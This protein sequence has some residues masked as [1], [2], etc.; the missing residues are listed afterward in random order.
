MYND[1]RSRLVNQIRFNRC[2]PDHLL[3]HAGTRVH[4]VIFQLG[5]FAAYKQDKHNQEARC[6][7]IAQS[8]RLWRYELHLMLT[9]RRLPG[10]SSTS[11]DSHSL[12]KS[13]NMERMRCRFCH[14][15]HIL[16]STLSLFSA[17]L[18]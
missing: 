16:E 18:D 12:I 17:G 14:E 15:L 13:P 6:D 3:M 9:V 4:C 1:L 10:P 7:I 5:V 8:S 11:M 2:S